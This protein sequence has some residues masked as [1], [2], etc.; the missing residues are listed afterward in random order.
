MFHVSTLLVSFSSDWLTQGADTFVWFK[1]ELPP[2]PGGAGF[3]ASPP[4]AAQV[5]PM[6]ANGPFLARHFNGMGHKRDMAT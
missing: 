2:G 1:P 4:P 3:L 6:A 5:R